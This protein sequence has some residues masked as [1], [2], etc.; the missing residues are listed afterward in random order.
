MRAATRAWAG[1]TEQNMALRYAVIALVFSSLS[2]AQNSPAPQSAPVPPAPVANGDWARL[3]RYRAENGTLKSDAS[4]IVYLGDSITEGWATTPFISENPH[5][6][7]RG[8]GGQTT[9]Q[10]LVRFRADVVDLRPKVVHIMGGTNDVAEN[11][12]P[13]SDQD[14][15]EAIASMVDLALAHQIK[16]VLASIPPAAD[17]RWRPGLD[18]APRLRRLNAWLKA[19]AAR[20]GI[21]Y[22]DYWPALAT[23]SGAMKS[24]FTSDGVH[25]NAA[26]YKAMEPLA[27]EAIKS[28]LHRR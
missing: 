13:E 23:D 21:I 26:G 16:V 5:F 11:N 1:L 7:G 22:V 25:P 6:V 18:P 17:F 15:E 2:L 28:A 8:I 12:G 14:I 20:A 10:M 24:E 4:R 3:A 19:Y 27:M 9:E